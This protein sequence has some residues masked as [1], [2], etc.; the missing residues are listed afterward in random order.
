MTSS[1]RALHPANP[2]ED[3]RERERGRVCV[4]V[5]G[6]WNFK[7][8]RSVIWVWTGL[9][10]GREGGGSLIRRSSKSRRSELSFY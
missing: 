8:W 6:Y 7:I 4:S 9:M 3:N 1:V 10:S 5:S 2:Q